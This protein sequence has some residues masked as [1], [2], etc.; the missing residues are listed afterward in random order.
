[1]YRTGNWLREKSTGDIYKIVSCGAL[2]TY[3]SHLREGEILAS[4][5]AQHFEL[6]DAQTERDDIERLLRAMI[7][8]GDAHPG[9]YNFGLAILLIEYND[10]GVLHV[11]WFDQPINL[12]D[13]L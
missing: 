7:R 11:R 2:I 13:L 1:M 9:L 12:Q 10:D 8:V 4:D 5:L 3:R 6:I